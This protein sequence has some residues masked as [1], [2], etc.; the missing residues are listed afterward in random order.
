MFGRGP[1]SAA[2]RLRGGTKAKQG[3]K[4]PLKARIRPPF[5]VLAPRQPAA[6]ITPRDRNFQVFGQV[7]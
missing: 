7:N 4:A 3:Y 5:P 2:E 6:G 1:G